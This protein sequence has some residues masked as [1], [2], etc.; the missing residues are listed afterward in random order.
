MMM[1]CVLKLAL[2]G[3]L[4][5]ARNRDVAGKRPHILHVVA[6][7]LGW[8]YVDWHRNDTEEKLTPRLY[9]EMKQGLELDRFYTFK[10]W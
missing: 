8:R 4:A 9:A 6:D 7:D 3:G 5:L 1:H 10:F 2:L